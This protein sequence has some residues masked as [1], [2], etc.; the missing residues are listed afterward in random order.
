MGRGSQILL[1]KVKN[2]SEKTMHWLLL[3]V[4]F[5]GGYFIGTMRATA[6]GGGHMKPQTKE[7]G[8]ATNAPVIE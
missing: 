1:F 3:A 8:Y 2:V 5:A 7:E 4:V 6:H